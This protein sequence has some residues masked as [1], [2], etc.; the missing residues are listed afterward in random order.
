VFEPEREDVARLSFP[1]KFT[2]YLATGVPVLFHGPS[3]TSGGR[4]L[5]RYDAGILCHSL[6]PDEVERALA[7]LVGDDAR[8][9]AVAANGLAAFRRDMTVERLSD[10]LRDVLMRIG[11][12][13]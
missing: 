9:H 3:H 13:P 12:Q 8:R 1:S 11:L 5:D 4:Y 10:R 7:V 6:A 2:P